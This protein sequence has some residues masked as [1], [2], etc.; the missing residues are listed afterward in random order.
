M[1]FGKSSPP[2]ASTAEV[3]AGT[4][5]SKIVSPAGLRAAM[6]Y[7]K[8]FESAE[9]T[10]PA[11]A[12]LLQVSHGLANAAKEV[13]VFA[14]AKSAVLGYSIGDTVLVADGFTSGSNSLGL[15]VYQDNATQISIRMGA[16]FGLVI[17]HKTTGVGTVATTTDWRFII[18]AK[19]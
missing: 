6:G 15:W 5:N 11:A 2:I 17:G 8:Y 12:G 9:Q 19:G 18:K 1:P 10:V 14:I 4:L 7:S 3:Q 13:Q 16:N